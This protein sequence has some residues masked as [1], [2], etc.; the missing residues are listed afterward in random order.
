MLNPRQTLGTLRGRARSKGERVVQRGHRIVRMTPDGLGFGN[1]LYLWLRSDLLQREGHDYRVLHVSAMDPWLELLPTVRDQ[2][3]VL[4]EDV[5][6]W[7]RRDPSWGQRFG[8]EFTRQQLRD[9]IRQHLLPS[10]LTRPEAARPRSVTVNVR[11]GDYYS[12]PVFRGRYSFDIEAYLDEALGRSV[13][14]G[15]PVDHVLVVSDGIE[16]CRTRLDRMLSRG[17]AEVEY[18]PQSASP[19]S[20]FHVVSTSSRIIGTNSTFSYWA[21]YVSNVI[22]GPHSQVVM[23]AFHARHMDGGRAYQL[24]PTWEIIHDIPGGWDG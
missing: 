17:G 22:H 4:R 20:N 24:D 19:A 11:R 16:W 8:E 5:R 3:L 9:F 18:A 21:G 14:V 13:D 12:D 10:E 15:G 23:P 1:F 6:V 7:D 2:L